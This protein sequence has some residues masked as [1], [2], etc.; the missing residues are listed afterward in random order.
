MTTLQ[1]R[2]LD[3]SSHD[4]R[5]TW[6]LIEALVFFSAVL[7]GLVTVPAGFVTDF[8]SV[9]RWVPLAFAFVGDSA[10]MAAVLH[11]WL[12]SCRLTSRADADAVLREAAV[13][14]GVPAWRA[15][16]LWAGVR[17]GGMAYWKAPA[18]PQPVATVAEAVA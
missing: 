9:P 5:G 12:Y 8:A 10:H 18:T 6:Q 13:A 1:V 17:V 3:D 15:W 14:S 11:D 4:G 16:I 7:G 2:E